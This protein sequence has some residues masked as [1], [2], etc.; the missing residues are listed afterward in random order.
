MRTT[1]YGI[2]TAWVLSLAPAAAADDKGKDFDKKIVG[3]WLLAKE[4]DGTPKGTPV[5]FSKDGQIKIN[6]DKDGVKVNISGTFTIKD[7]TISVKLKDSQGNEVN[8][9][10]TIKELTDSKL[11]IETK[12]G[13]QMEF[14]KKK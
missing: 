12:E 9:T 7:T 10:G 11:V 1:V 13:K 8:N 5:E 3:T 4:F 6:I 2:V 14:E